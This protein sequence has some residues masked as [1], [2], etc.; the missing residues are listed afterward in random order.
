ME[1]LEI[2][3][4]KRHGGPYDRG[5]ADCYYNRPLL[6]HYFKG[7]TYFSEKVNVDDMTP[8]EIEAY[9][10]GYDQQTERKSWRD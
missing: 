1:T 2:S 8:E 6:P 9:T 10:A 5:S 4:D 3:Y 7:D